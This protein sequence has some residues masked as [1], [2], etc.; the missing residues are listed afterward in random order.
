MD[1]SSP[2][3]TE[4]SPAVGATVDPGVQVDVILTLTLTIAVSPD[5]GAKVNPA[6]QVDIVD[7]YLTVI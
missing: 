5:V 7:V 3:V 4:Y 1:T 2:F 6:V